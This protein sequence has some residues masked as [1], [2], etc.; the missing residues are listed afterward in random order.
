M[1]AP[2][3]Q[4]TAT[5]QRRRIALFI[6]YTATV[7]ACDEV[8]DRLLAAGESVTCYHGRMSTAERN[9]NQDAFMRGER[10]V[11]VATNAFGM[12]IDKADV[13][14]LIHY[15]YPTAEDLQAV[16]AVLTAVPHPV[17]VDEIADALK[18]VPAQP[19][20]RRAAAA[21]RRRHRRHPP[22]ERP[23]HE[24]EEPVTLPSAHMVASRPAMKCACRATA[25][26]GWSGW[27][28]TR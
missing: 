26:G 19:D 18:A 23:V 24:E 7:K 25:A 20:Q 10:R 11:M 15:Q 2:D 21:A 12:G 14:F 28:A 8:H 5:L 9:T 6:V 17:S 22:A 13:R 4:F 3:T 1:V 16:H 27:R